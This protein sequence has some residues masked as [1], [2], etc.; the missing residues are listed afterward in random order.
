MGFEFSCKNLT[1]GSL[2]LSCLNS[3][4]VE[5]NNLAFYEFD[6]C[7][8]GM[9]SLECNTLVEKRSER[10]LNYFKGFAGYKTAEYLLDET[11]YLPITKRAIHFI[12]DLRTFETNSGIYFY[13]GDRLQVKD[14]LGVK[15]SYLEAK[16]DFESG[17]KID[18]FKLEYSYRF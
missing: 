3:T 5:A 1:I 4:D 17:F 14:F 2:L 15:N 7:Y 12:D 6:S 11:G 13:G 8:A 10:A 9:S 16:L 18:G